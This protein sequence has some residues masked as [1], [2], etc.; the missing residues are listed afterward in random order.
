MV[1]KIL[2]IP[3]LIIE[4]VSKTFAE[5]RQVEWLSRSMTLKYSLYVVIFLVIGT[6]LIVLIDALF[7]SIRS[8]VIS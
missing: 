7:L 6:V 3:K 1:N 2:F 8:I 5:L 4:F